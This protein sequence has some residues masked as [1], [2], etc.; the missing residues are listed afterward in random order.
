MIEFDRELERP[1]HLT[2]QASA[3]IRFAEGWFELDRASQMLTHRQRVRYTSPRSQPA[4]KTITIKIPS[5]IFTDA[6]GKR[7]LQ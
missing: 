3:L 4:Q 2:P 1:Q 5:L 7:Q 6:I